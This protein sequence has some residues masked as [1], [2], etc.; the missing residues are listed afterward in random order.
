V[1]PVDKLVAVARHNPAA[2]S[3]EALD[4]A[5]VI[6]VLRATT[7]AVVLLAAGV[8]SVR[9]VATADRL[10][11]LPPA[12]YLVFSELD[13]SRAHGLECVDNSPRLAAELPLEGRLPV[14]VTGNGTR[15]IAAAIGRSRQVLIAGF[16]NL[17]STAAYLRARG[18]RVAL[19]P[20]GDFE[21]MSPR[22]EDERCADGLERL[23]AGADA[24]LPALLAEC[25]ADP[26]V[27]SRL[28]SHPGLVPDV[29]MALSVDRHPM[30]AAA[31]SGPD[32]LSL[33]RIA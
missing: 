19:L 1:E 14:L 2:L 7:T 16:V 18:G 30:V 8:P 24:G 28:A 26:R 31:V 6:D 27:V 13:E 22:T 3:D 20:A 11:D 9:V 5:V 10:R 33:R 15:A 17:S 29:E 32:G 21:R 23:I 4:V 25:R 12:R